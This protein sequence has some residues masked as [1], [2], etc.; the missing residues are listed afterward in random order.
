MAEDPRIDALKKRIQRDPGSIAFAQLAEEYRRAGRFQE[1]I[2]VCR[3][4]LAR[5]PGYLS[6]RVTLGRALLEVGDI[7]S[8]HREFSDVIRVAPGNLSAIRGL[9]EVHRRRGELPEA[10]EQFRSAFELAGPDPAIEQIVRDLRREAMQAPLPAEPG[11]ASESAPGSYAAG[12][13]PTR[14]AASEEQRA[15]RRTVAYLER[16]LEAIVADRRS[17]LFASRA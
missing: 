8:A 1:S 10:I 16:W 14:P 12:H 7:D 17:R 4:G 2:E 15:A 6:A 13:A 9:A 5:H 3:A 11:R